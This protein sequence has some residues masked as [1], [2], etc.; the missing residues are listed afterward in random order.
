MIKWEI[1]NKVVINCLKNRD[2]DVETLKE[3]TKIFINM[4]L[5][6]KI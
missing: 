5:W 3:I 2:V 1:L 4:I 6:R